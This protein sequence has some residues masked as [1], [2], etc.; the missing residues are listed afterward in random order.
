MSGHN[1]YLGRHGSRLAVMIGNDFLQ[2]NGKRPVEYEPLLPFAEAQD[3]L[4]PLIS[5]T[6]PETRAT[7]TEAA[8]SV[9]ETK[10]TQRQR[11]YEAIR[12]AG[13]NGMTD[14][15]LQEDLGIEG[16]SQRPR[17]REL[18]ALGR[19]QMCTLRRKTRSGRTAVVWVVV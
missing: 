18:Q 9:R 7:S 8:T 1:E 10:D 15:Q 16:N 5:G 13:R 4:R 19:I 11:V 3:A 12:D 17:R 2:A 6:T 14:D